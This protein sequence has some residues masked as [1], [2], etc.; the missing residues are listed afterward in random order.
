MTPPKTS[1]QTEA[2]P[3][4]KTYGYYVRIVEPGRHVF[5]ARMSTQRTVYAVVAIGLISYCARF[6]FLVR[7]DART[8]TGVNLWLDIVLIF[9]AWGGGLTLFV[10]WGWF[11]LRNTVVEIT[12][13]RISMRRK[14]F[15]RWVEQRSWDVSSFHGA[16]LQ[17]SFDFHVGGQTALLTPMLVFDAGDNFLMDFTFTSPQEAAEF[18]GDIESSVARALTAPETF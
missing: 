1:A 7:S 13:R 8:S 2:L 12:A 5:K 3:H 6:G 10:V 16:L 15:F 14:R 17:E 11:V 18:A 4:E 9:L